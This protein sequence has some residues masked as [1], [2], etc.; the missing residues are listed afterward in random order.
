MHLYNLF[1]IFQAKS[2]DNFERN[3]EVPFSKNI[4]ESNL[5]ILKNVYGIY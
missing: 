5:L 1:I 4:S 3:S 2:K